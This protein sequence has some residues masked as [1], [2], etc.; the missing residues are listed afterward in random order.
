MAVKKKPT[1][2]KK[3]IARKKPSERR[4]KPRITRLKLHDKLYRRQRPNLLQWLRWRDRGELGMDVRRRCLGSIHC[5][6]GVFACGLGGFCPLA[7]RRR[8]ILRDLLPSFRLC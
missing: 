8:F 6:L 7:W 4:F 3:P 2:K 5:K 1:A